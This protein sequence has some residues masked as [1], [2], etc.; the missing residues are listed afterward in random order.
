MCAFNNVFFDRYTKVRSI[1]GLNLFSFFTS[2][3]KKANNIAV[4]CI[5][6]LQLSCTLKVSKFL[7]KVSMKFIDLSIVYSCGLLTVK[8]IWFSLQ[9]NSIFYIFIIIYWKIII[10]SLVFW[11]VRNI[12]IFSLLCICNLNSQLKLSTI[13][14]VP[15]L[16]SPRSISMHRGLWR[17]SRVLDLC[18][19]IST[20]VLLILDLRVTPKN[21]GKNQI[22][23]S[24]FLVVSGW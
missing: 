3:S 12:F 8:T 5:Y 2:H 20:I 19:A 6:L 16:V 10:K 14:N 22:D 1:Y 9:K 23:S 11:L 24:V 13:D 7:T 18:Q 21:N 17:N 4:A 15:S